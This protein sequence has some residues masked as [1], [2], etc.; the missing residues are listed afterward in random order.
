MLTR[1]GRFVIPTEPMEFLIPA[2]TARPGD[3]PIFALN[4]EAQA[5]KK[6]GESVVNATVGALLDDDGKLAIISGVVDALREVPPEVGAAYAP[7]A[8]P[9]A[10]LQAVIADVLGQRPAAAWAT[11]VA[12]PGGSGALRHAITNFLEP[13]QMLLTSGFYWGP[14]KT[15]AD[16]ADRTLT[17]FRMF[18][19]RGKLDVADLDRKLQGVLDAQGRA[20]VFLNTPCHNPTGYS[21][22][23]D[24]F[25]GVEDAVRRASKRG[26]VVVLIDFAYARYGRRDPS[27]TVDA[28]LRLANDAMVLFAWSSSKSFTQYGLRVGALVAVCP[29]AA[30]RTRVQS[31]LSFACRGTWSNCNAAGLS[32][33]TRCLV[34]PDLRLRIERER[35]ALKALLDGRVARW[36]ELASAAGLVYPRYDGGFFTTVFCDDATRVAARLRD[37]GI[38]VVPAQGALRVGLCSVPERDIERLVNGFRK[39]MNG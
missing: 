13:Q 39:A 25:R 8:G 35:S 23:A 9:P 2:R 27:E 7:I 20:L 22:D 1:V 12:T 28:A 10:F 36:N 24:D 4:A 34:D 38:F 5:R 31:A 16:E 37:E 15:L 33:I 21:L 6:A 3:D 18:D 26:P 14:Y 30:E 29:D 17:T 32:A 19:D 11:A